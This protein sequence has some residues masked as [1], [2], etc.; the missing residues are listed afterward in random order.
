MASKGWRN[1]GKSKC[2]VTT[3][4]PCNRNWKRQYKLPLEQISSVIEVYIATDAD[5]IIDT[6]KDIL[7]DLKEPDLIPLWKQYV[8]QDRIFY[9]ENGKIYIPNDQASH[10]DIVKLHH[11]TPVAGHS[12]REKILELVQRSYIYLA[13]NKYIH[14]GIHKPM[15]KMCS[16]ETI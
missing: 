6:I 7:F 14:Q 4:R 2:S 12:G 10:L 9:N 13:W 16:N 8:L 5:I 15:W 11:D 1:H 3:N